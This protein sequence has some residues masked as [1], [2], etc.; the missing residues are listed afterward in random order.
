MVDKQRKSNLW[1]IKESE[2]VTCNVTCHTPIVTGNFVSPARMPRLPL[3]IFAAIRVPPRLAVV[4]AATVLARLPPR[5]QPI[6]RPSLFNAQPLMQPSSFLYS[7]P[8]YQLPVRFKSRGTEYQPSQRKRKRKHGFLAR[9]R[10]VGGRR[11][12]ARRMAKGRK[13]LSH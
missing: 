10:S 11:V 5:V 8:F 9:K 6:Q 3:S 13:H 12:L 2:H 4:R 1:C 7:N